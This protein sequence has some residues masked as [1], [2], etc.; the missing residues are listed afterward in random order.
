MNVVIYGICGKMGRT[1]IS[2]AADFPD[3]K[4]IGGVD[5]MCNTSASDCCGGIATYKSAAEIKVKP[6]IIIDFSR[7][8]SLSDI[9]S[10]ALKNKVKLVLCT[11]GYSAADEK[12]ISD[13][14]KE[15]A[16]F[17]SGNMSIGVNL[18]VDLIAQASKALGDA[19]DIEIVE[20]HHNQK[21][22]APSG[23]ALMLAEAANSAFDG[24]KKYVYGRGGADCK[25]DR[26]EIG[27]HAVR[28]GTLPGEH[29]VMF[30]G[31]DEV[32]SIS[33]TAFSKKIFASGAFRAALSLKDKQSGLYSF[34]RK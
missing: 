29:E 17:K 24:K 4:I 20:K 26:S 1:L 33:H 23:T 13:A 15:I 21:V 22:D 31:C 2:A 9:L 5:A 28:G 14:A 27:I 30:I 19:Y 10:Y 8:S 16:I 18:I 3:I 12:K 25:R 34:K 32:I 6:D 7:P 11:T